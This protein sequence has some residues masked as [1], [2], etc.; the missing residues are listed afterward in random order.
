MEKKPLS[1]SIKTF[2]GI[3]D[4]GFG[5]MASVELYFFVFFLTNVAKLSLPT[6]AL[7]SSITSIV[8]AVSS[9]FYGAIISGTKP[10]K[11]GRNRSWILIMPPLVVIFYI[12]QFSK[13]GPESV[14]ALIICAGF[15]LSHIAW[16]L[17]WVANV[18]LIP[19]LASDPDE[20]ALLASRRATW[21]ALSGIVFSYTGAPLAEYFGRVTNNEVLGYTI[22]AGLT[23][24]IMMFCYWIVF[25]ITEGYEP[26][27]K[28][29]QDTTQAQK[30]S[31]AAMVKSLVQN[32][33]LIVLLISDFFRNM[34]LFV[35]TAAAAY[36]FTYVAQNMG[37]FSAYLLIVSIATMIG[38][39]LAGSVAK[40][41]SSR[42]ATIF[43]LYALGILLIICK[44]VALNVAMFFI[45]ITISS[46][47]TGILTSVTVSLY[48]DVSI[49]A[50]WKTGEDASPF[51]MGLMTVALKLAVI[52]RGMV[53]PFVLAS[54][55]F[56]PGIDPASATEA[57]K[58]GVINAFLFIPGIFALIGAVILHLGYRL[59][60]EK[61]IE[62][63]NEINK[64]LAQQA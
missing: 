53:I 24:L 10:L 63:Q 37:L 64:R 40:K 51:V 23:G 39:Y 32:P 14:A 16:N 45:V 28:A 22:L 34:V 61:V 3:G 12:F 33:P 25:K 44:F 58:I 27:G 43:G 7:I 19:V 5:L 6:V 60:R 56:T 1:K 31:L 54:V 30:V 48:S 47:F 21:T 38:S 55:G 8:D 4:F 35:M 57:L 41:M 52:S 59:T 29:A 62:Y 50:Y 18:A 26:T 49:Y 15:I 46:I 20:A 2:Y 36:Y 9:P 42:N 11:W 13:I 17:P